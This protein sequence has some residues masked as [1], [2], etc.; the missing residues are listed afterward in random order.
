MST[1]LRP[2]ALSLV[3]M[4]ALAGCSAPRTGLAVEPAELATR[5]ATPVAAMTTGVAAAATSAAAP[6]VRVEAGRAAATPTAA[7]PA[8]YLR[9]VGH[10]DLSRAELREDAED[11][12]YRVQSSVSVPSVTG[13]VRRSAGVNYLLEAKRNHL[14]VKTPTPTTYTLKTSDEAIRLWLAQH[15]NDKV[16]VKGLFT[17]DNAVTVTFADKAIDLGFLTD[18]WTKGKL[19]GTLVGADGLPL[20]NVEVKA[21]SSAG[22]VFL[23]NTDD[24]G[25]FALRNLAPGDYQIWL[26]KVGYGVVSRLIEIKAH[27]ATDVEGKLYKN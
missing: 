18:W 7:T 17:A 1:R 14:G 2:V 3:A 5:T 4:L 21:R 15:V 20:V 22:Y 26:S 16:N 11:G 25:A 24:T 8:G 6:S 12:G 13:H 9:V 27:K 19:R 10:S 23:G